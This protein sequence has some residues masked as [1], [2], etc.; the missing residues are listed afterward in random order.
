MGFINDLQFGKKYEALAR[1]TYLPEDEKVIEIPEGKFKPYD[2]KTNLFAYESKADRLAYKY[3]YKTMFIEYECNG[4]G[5]G[6]STT[7]ADYWFYFMVKPGG[8][9]IVYEIPIAK[10]RE[11]C[12][13]C[14]QVSGG[15]GGRAKG[16]IVPVLEEFKI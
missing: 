9:Y 2:F 16:Y 5:S 10:L 13:G 14:R 6:I 11:A 1:S 15:D 8:D 3:N 12:N 7:Q 4:V